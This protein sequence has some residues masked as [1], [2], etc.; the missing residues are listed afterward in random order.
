VT[1]D[2]V[3]AI[4]T[5][6][7]GDGVEV[8]KVIRGKDEVWDSL[9]SLGILFELEEV[10]N[11]TFSDDEISQLNSLAEIVSILDAKAK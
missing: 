6:A 3:R 8:D 11:V 2:K 10:F 1:T 7:L 5:K 4:L 9:A